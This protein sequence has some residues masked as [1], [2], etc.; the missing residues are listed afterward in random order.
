MSSQALKRSRES[1]SWQPL[2]TASFSGRGSL[3]LQT[4]G[5]CVH[6][7]QRVRRAR[8]VVSSLPDGVEVCMRSNHCRGTRQK[9]PAICSRGRPGSLGRRP[10]RSIA[11]MSALT[12]GLEM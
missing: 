9:V 6:S 1:A 2:R 5:T 10:Y 4:R 7:E 3:L 12:R 8:A 11:M